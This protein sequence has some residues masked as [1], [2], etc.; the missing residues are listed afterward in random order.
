MITPK[1]RPRQINADDLDAIRA[2]F[3]SDMTESRPV[4]E[5]SDRGITLNKQLAWTI[6]GGLIGA[7]LYVGL[8]IATLSTQVAQ[9]REA[10][11]EATLARQQ[12]ETRVRAVEIAQASQTSDLRAIQVGITEIKAAISKIGDAP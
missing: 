2:E 12:L 11:A 3:T 9:S 4:I 7:G 8:T 1:P 5:N 10:W 6:G